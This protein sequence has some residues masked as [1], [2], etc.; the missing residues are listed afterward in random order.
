MASDNQATGDS[1]D[2]VSLQTVEKVNR[3]PWNVDR[4]GR[5]T[6]LKQSIVVAV[7]LHGHVS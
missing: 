7:A 2:I 4:N 3:N 5:Y 6:G 1:Q